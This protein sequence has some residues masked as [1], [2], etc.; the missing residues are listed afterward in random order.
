M[1]KP[2]KFK[3]YLRDYGPVLFDSGIPIGWGF[4]VKE[5]LG[6]ILWEE[7]KTHGNLTVVDGQGTPYCQWALITKYLTHDEAIALYGP[8]TSR[9]CGPKG[10]FISIPFGATKFYS[11]TL[12]KPD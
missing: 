1:V 8:V 5:R 10:G 11:R 2:V 7:F 6:P 9:E 4:L 3:K 12:R